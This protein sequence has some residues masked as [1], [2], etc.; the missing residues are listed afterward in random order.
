MAKKIAFGVVGLLFRRY[1]FPAGPV[2]LG[3]D[4]PEYTESALLSPG[5][6]EELL[7]DLRG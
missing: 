4:H 3:L 6:V 2:V 7:S 5:T 1:G